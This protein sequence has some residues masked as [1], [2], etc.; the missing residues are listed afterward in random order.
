MREYDLAT[1]AVDMVHERHARAG[2]HEQARQAA[3][4]LLDGR[5]SQILSI[6]LEQVD[7]R[8]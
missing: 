7:L 6:Q 2:Q 1:A 4:A 3:L 8:T 5:R